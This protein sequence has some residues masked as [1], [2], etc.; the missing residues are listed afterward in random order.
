MPD[1][2]L[3]ALAE[4]GKLNQPEVLSAEIKRMLAD[5]RSWQFV[6]Q[7]TI[8]WLDLG[9]VDRVAVNPEYYPKFDNALKADMQR[10]TRLFF[11][12]VLHK[13]LSA[14]NFSTRTSP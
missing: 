8:Q 14:M 5:E 3:M 10:E 2:R 9:G 7:F 12:E 11:A 6:E 13:N 4:N 1:E